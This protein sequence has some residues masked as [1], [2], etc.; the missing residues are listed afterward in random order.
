MLSVN[1]MEQQVSRKIFS[2][3]SLGHT[4]THRTVSYTLRYIFIVT[5][6]P[7]DTSIAPIQ[8]GTYRT[9]TVCS[10][11]FISNYRSLNRCLLSDEDEVVLCGQIISYISNNYFGSFIT[12]EQ[13]AILTYLL[14]RVISPLVPM[15]VKK[16]LGHI[17]SWLS[18][19]E[20][21]SVSALHF[22]VAQEPLDVTGRCG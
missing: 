15:S 19:L 14:V 8:I 4:N 6:R 9:Q 10:L 12:W 22:I 2:H 21:K 5:S 18:P 1:L 3:V 20:A 16:V 7:T 11:Q 17:S 13:S